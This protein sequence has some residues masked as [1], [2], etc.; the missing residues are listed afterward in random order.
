MACRLDGA[1]PLSELILP[2]H[3]SVTRPQWVIQ[4]N[5]ININTLQFH[6]DQWSSTEFHKTLQGFHGLPWEILWN[7]MELS[8]FSLDLDASI[9]F[10]WMLTPLLL[11]RTICWKKSVSVDSRRLALTLTWRQCNALFP[12]NCHIPALYYF[13]CL[14][15]ISDWFSGFI[16]HVYPYPAW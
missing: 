15:Y 7:S 16:R 12:K 1:K 10:L 5:A 3:I 4:H 2:T 14:Q 11:T 8:K 6:G 9:K 13:V